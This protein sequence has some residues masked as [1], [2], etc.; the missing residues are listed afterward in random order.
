[1]ED[2]W[3]WWRVDGDMYIEGGLWVVVVESGWVMSG[4]RM[5]GFGGEQMGDRYIEGDDG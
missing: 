2:E 1:M 4:G 5:T 3:L